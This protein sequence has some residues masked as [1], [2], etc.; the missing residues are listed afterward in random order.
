MTPAAARWVRTVTERPVHLVEP[1][2]RWTLC[3]LSSGSW[4]RTPY[5][6]HRAPRRGDECPTCLAGLARRERDG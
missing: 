4:P 2:E 1:G 3:G 6:S 5:K